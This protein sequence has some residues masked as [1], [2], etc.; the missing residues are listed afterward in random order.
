MFGCGTD[1]SPAKGRDPYRQ[2]AVQK[3]AARVSRAASERS[4]RAKATS[5]GADE[6]FGEIDAA[7]EAYRQAMALG[8]DEAAALD[9][10]RLL[11]S[12]G[13]L[14]EARALTSWLAIQATSTEIRKSAAILAS[15]IE[16]RQGAARR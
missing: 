6:C 10:A 11:T 13:E 15:L 3:S 12:S 5:G 16:R 2:P 14:E 8:G 4:G 9:L 7:A 1:D